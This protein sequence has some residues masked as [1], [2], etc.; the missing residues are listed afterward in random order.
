VSAAIAIGNC[1]VKNEPE[2]DARDS[3]KRCLEFFARPVILS[4]DTELKYIFGL[5]NFNISDYKLK[6]Q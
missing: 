2:P 5:C 4:E 3:W 1:I 6:N